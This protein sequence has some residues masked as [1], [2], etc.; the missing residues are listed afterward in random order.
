MFDGIDDKPRN[1]RLAEPG[2]ACG[3]GGGAAP[4]RLAGALDAEGVRGL[5]EMFVTL[6]ASGA[7]DVVLDFSDVLFLDG[8]GM[9]LLALLFRRLSAQGGTLRV[10]GAADQPLSTLH[11]LGLAHVL[12]IPA[13]RRAG[14]RGREASAAFRGA[15]VAR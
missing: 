13:R 5:R 9:G 4:V 1:G 3:A 11:D 12:G 7:R 6:A 15:G 14:G 2:R 8:A 10:I